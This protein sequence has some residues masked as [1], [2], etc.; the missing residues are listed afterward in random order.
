MPERKTRVPPKD[1]NKETP[2]DKVP[3]EDKGKEFKL[4]VADIMKDVEDAIKDTEQ[5]LAANKQS[6]AQ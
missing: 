5:E 2:Q 1:K 4:P 6:S 3:A